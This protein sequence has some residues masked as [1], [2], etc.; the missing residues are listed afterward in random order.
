MPVI[1]KD[2]KFSEGWGVNSKKN[3]APGT[4]GY[5]GVLS[6]SNEIWS[7]MEPA[8]QYG[9]QMIDS[10]INPASNFLFD[11][12]EVTITLD[13]PEALK[14]L[15]M[16]QDV[17]ISINVQDACGSGSPYF[18][19]PS[20][21]RPQYWSYRTVVPEKLTFTF[22][23]PIRAISSFSVYAYLITQDFR[24]IEVF[25]DNFRYRRYKG[26]IPGCQQCGSRGGDRCE[27]P[28]ILPR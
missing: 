5:L 3:Y 4:P 25:M 18:N 10:Y 19:A 23:E 1:Y 2:F 12:E 22:A 6:P 21:L 17:Q 9:L 14:N 24:Q 13:L 16:L 11:F 7:G 20:F 27:V 15:T 28:V 8:N 26:P